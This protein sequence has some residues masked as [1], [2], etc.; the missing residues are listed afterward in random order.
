MIN[1]NDQN[2]NIGPTNELSLRVS[3]A[4]L[5]RVVFP[6][7]GDGIAMMALE[8]KATLV[9]SAQQS[10]VDVKAQPFGGAIRILNLNSVLSIIGNFNFDSERSRAEQ[11]FR[12]FIQPSTWEAVKDYCL[13]NLDQENGGNLD[14]DPSRELMEEF[15]DALGF[16]LKTEHYAVKP[17]RIVVENEPAP[18]TN[19]HVAGR[20]T[21]RIYRIYEVQLR[22]LALSNLMI[23]NSEKHSQQVMRRL[24]LEDAQKGGRGRANSI[25]AAPLEEIRNAFLAAPG[26]LGMPIPYGNTILEGN[27]PAVLEGFS[28]L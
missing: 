16:Q 14:S 10:R 1:V 17:V 13:R 24:V 3:V 2:I 20:L 27:V 19:V 15:D 7:P 21:A 8:H 4:T 23:A 28:S 9:S 6:R 18:T 5:C 12:V 25:F 22:D 11:D 26:K